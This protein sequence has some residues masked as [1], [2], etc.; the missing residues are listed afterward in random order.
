[1][2][3]PIVG[4]P[5]CHLCLAIALFLTSHHAFSN[6][7][8]DGVLELNTYGTFGIARSSRDT[9]VYRSNSSYQYGLDDSWSTR[10]DSRIGVQATVNSGSQLAFTGQVL[11]R[12]NGGDEFAPEVTWGYARWRP[13][14]H[15]E[16]RLGRFR[17]PL[18]LS[19]ESFDV[20]YAQP[21]AR[22]PV[23]VY[24]LAGESTSVDGIQLRYR[25][26]IMGMNLN[27]DAHAGRLEIH[28]P[29]YDAKNTPNA[30]FSLSLVD[31]HLTIKLS[32]IQAKVQYSA[33]RL[34]SMTSLIAAQNPSVAAE[35]DARRIPDM[36]YGAL[37]LRYENDEWL[38]MSEL[39]MTNLQRKSLPD[40][41]AAYITLGRSFGDWMPYISLSRVRVTSSLTESRLSG[42][43]ATAANAFLS[44][45]NIGQ[46]TLSA[47]VRWDFMPGA[48]LKV[49]FDHVT[50]EKGAYGLLAAPLPSGVSH[51]NVSTLLVDWAF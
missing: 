32:F 10:L 38:L 30:G 40:Q 43:A 24:G 16:I 41:L 4:N 23:E 34:E 50:P 19:T 27:A 20:G 5:I 31:Q 3:R 28:R 25:L 8:D 17:Q 11:A 13:D 2:S 7:L 29:T 39:A 46:H 48:A 45:R 9:P 33:S 51:V 44:A 37:G 36:R 14:E 21:W 22:A 49:Q 1:M 26:P 15:I 6:G 12:R 35:Y 18:F 47:G 42:T